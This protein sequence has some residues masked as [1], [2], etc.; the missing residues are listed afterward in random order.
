LNAFDNWKSAGRNND[1]AVS[2]SQSVIR[3]Y[4]RAEIQIR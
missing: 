1:L 3:R 2:I 4:N